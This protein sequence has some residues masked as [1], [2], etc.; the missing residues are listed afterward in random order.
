MDNSYLMG[1]EAQSGFSKSDFHYK[2]SISLKEMSE[3]NY[4]LRNYYGITC[5]FDLFFFPLS[6]LKF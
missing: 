2:V 4:W 6:S 3:S 1:Q 5:H